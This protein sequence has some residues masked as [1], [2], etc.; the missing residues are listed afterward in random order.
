VII[1]TG[2]AGFIGSALI[3]KLNEMGRDDILVV[4][5]LSRDERWQNLS[6][7]RFQDYRQSGDFLLDIEA[8]V[9]DDHAEAI[10]HL[11]ACSSTT[12]TDVAFL[13]RNNFEYTKSLARFA[14]RSRARFIYASSA[15]TYGDGAN[16]YS[17]DH[18]A[19]EAL[20]PLNAYAFSKQLFDIWA[21]RQ[22][23][24]DRIV[25]LKYFNVFG[26]N[27]WH[28]GDMRS[29]VAKGFEQ[30]QQTGKIRLFKS[31]RPEYVDGGQERDFIYVKD[32]V[33]MTAW[34]MEHPETNGIFN[35]GLGQ[36]TTWNALITAIFEALGREPNIEYADMPEHLKGKYQYHTCAEM[37]KIRLA[38]CEKPMT[39]IPEAVGDYVTSYLLPERLLES[40]R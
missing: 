7:L 38:G 9:F 22:G 20:R 34:F 24:L 36:A 4:D 21:L 15:A 11:G 2:G 17:D 8:G 27:E 33:E 40:R 18:A 1:V 26:P 10:F 30:I 19:I 3:W 37:D 13:V 12:E 39:S 25:G 16:G 28:K 14:V 31:D 32:A 35:I 5:T 6:G 23:F 29:M